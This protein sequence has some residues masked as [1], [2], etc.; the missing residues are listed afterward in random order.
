MDTAGVPSFL[1]DQEHYDYVRLMLEQRR[2]RPLLVDLLATD[3][4]VALGEA[5]KALGV[6][7]RVLYLSNAEQYWKRYPKQFRANITALPFADDA[8]VLRTLLSQAINE[9]YRYNVQPAA[10]Y[11][12]WLERPFVGNVYQ[13]V[14]G[15]PKATPE[16]ITLF[17][18]D[19]DPDQSAAGQRYHARHEE[20]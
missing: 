13:I 14:R 4:L 11:E 1:T 9:D 19:A 15:G 12:E 18:T 10:N 8:V 5:S 20:G 17:E 16:G 7:I 3:G 6:P 2:V